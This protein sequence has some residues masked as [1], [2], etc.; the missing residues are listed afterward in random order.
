VPRKED[1][2][3]TQFPR[4]PE[5]SPSAPMGVP[6]AQQKGADKKSL[7]DRKLLLGVRAGS[8][9]VGHGEVG[10]V[11]VCLCPHQPV[12]DRNLLGEPALGAGAWVVQ[13][14]G[15]KKSV[16]SGAAIDE[17]FPP[18]NRHVIV[19]GRKRPLELPCGMGANPHYSTR[20]KRTTAPTFPF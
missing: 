3:D 1:L 19:W 7:S 17:G 12:A 6:H 4:L 2:E 13:G 8:G 16:S 5:C 11:G 10:W 20:L 9:C 18:R 15:G 14:G